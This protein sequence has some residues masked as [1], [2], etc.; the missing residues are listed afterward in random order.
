LVG[1]GRLGRPVRAEN[2]PGFHP[3]GC[4]AVHRVHGVIPGASRAK[5]VQLGGD[6]PLVL[7]GPESMSV[8]P[9]RSGR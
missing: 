5:P 9:A 1:A 2:R 3:L 8:G 7:V 6:G 4:P